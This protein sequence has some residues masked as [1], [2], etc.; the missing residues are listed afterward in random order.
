VEEDVAD[1]LP[2]ILLAHDESAIDTEA[3]S[4]HQAH[5]A[6]SGEIGG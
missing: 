5:V 3:A 2:G 1:G 4:V 6:A